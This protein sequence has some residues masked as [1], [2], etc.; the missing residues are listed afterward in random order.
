MV[1]MTEA[2]DAMRWAFI[3]LSAGK[4][5]VPQRTTLNIPDKNASSL[6]MPAY[7][8][9]SPFYSVKTVSI[10]YS[11]PHK[12]LPLI[13]AVVQIFDASKGNLV[14]TLDGGSITAVRTA[15][16]SGLAT[17]LLVKDDASVCAIFGTG[18][19]AESH[20][21]AIM[22]VRDIKKFIIVSRTKE[23]AARFIESQSIEIEFEIGSEESIQDADIICTTTPSKIP[24]FN[25]E[26]VKDG[27]HVNVIGSHKP[28]YREVTTKTVVKSKVVVDSIDACK[29]EAGDLLIPIEEGKWSFEKLHGE[30]G[31]IASGNIPGRESNDKI[32][33]F[34]SVGVAIQDLAMANLI[35]KKLNRD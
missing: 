34:K 19:Q 24:L 21:E 22:T 13:N 4:A 8:L 3:Q 29:N 10:N 9:D 17:D 32:T 27:C 30:I 15:A 26:L 23:A 7:A 33:L 31:R 2:I 18:V 28:D 5:F 14:A 16:A 6:V 1:S 12:G 20:L 35:M 11:N 25:H